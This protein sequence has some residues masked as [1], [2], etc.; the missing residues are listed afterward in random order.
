MKTV[1]RR[2]NSALKRGDR[3]AFLLA[4]RQGVTKS[5]GM[6][7]LSRRARLSRESLYRMLSAHGNPEIKS[8]SALLAAMGLTLCLIPRPKARR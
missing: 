6:S 8:L 5:G 2:A 4:L 3:K 1:I 7:A